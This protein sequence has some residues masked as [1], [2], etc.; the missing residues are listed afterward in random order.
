MLLHG[1]LKGRGVILDDEPTDIPE[2]TPVEVVVQVG[3][4]GQASGLCGIWNDARPAG[5][6]VRELREA[7]TGYGGRTP[8]L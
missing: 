1:K 8:P 2:G 7:R 4:P 6:I 5:A 3:E